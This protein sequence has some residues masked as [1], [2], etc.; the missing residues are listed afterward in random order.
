MKRLKQITKRKLDW[1]YTYHTLTD[2][3]ECDKE[4]T[5]KIMANFKDKPSDYKRE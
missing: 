1:A 4:L 2:Y 3:Y 5:K